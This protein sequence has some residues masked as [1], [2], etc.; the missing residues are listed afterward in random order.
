MDR[1]YRVLSRAILAT[2]VIAPAFIATKV[3]ADNRGWNTIL[4]QFK[5]LWLWLQ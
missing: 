5:L 3:A 4:L 1:N 2:A